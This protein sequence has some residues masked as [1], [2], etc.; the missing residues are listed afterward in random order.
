MLR[1]VDVQA[2]ARKL[3]GHLRQLLVRPETGESCDAALLDR[4]IASRDEIAF[5]ALVRRHG[6]LV[7]NVCRQVVG[8][9]HERSG[10]PRVLLDP[11][12]FGISLR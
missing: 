5:A 1:G 10:G 7:L 9:A 3:V 12:H 8:A 2:N 4:F 6:S 11:L